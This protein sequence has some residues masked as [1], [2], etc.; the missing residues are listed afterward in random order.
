MSSFGEIISD[1]KDT[2]VEFGS[3]TYNEITNSNGV[4]S[5]VTN[6][7]GDGVNKVGDLFNSGMDGIRLIFGIK[8]DSTGDGDPDNIS[9]NIGGGDD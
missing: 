2:V 9:E 8:E 6:I 4:V 3:N 7:A 5:S 1:V